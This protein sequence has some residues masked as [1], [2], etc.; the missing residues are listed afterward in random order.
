MTRRERLADW[1]SGGALSRAQNAKDRAEQ[2][3]QLS[4]QTAD[5]AFEAAGGYCMTVQT[6]TKTLRAIITA[7]D[8]GKSGTARKINRIARGGLE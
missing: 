4:R 3:E 2:L 6:R 5:Y 7:T 8:N 1:I